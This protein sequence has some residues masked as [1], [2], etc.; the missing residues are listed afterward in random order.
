VTGIGSD[1]TTSDT[2]VPVA[3]GIIAALVGVK[4]ALHLFTN[5]FSP[6]EFH[7]D[8]FLYFAMGEHL[9]LWHMDFPPFIAMLSEATRGLLGDSL[10]A[11]RLPPALLGT[12]LLVFAALTARELGGGRFAQ[13]LAGFGVLSSVIFLRA[14]NLFQP[15]VVE[16]LCWTVGLFCLLKLCKS[17]HHRWWIAFGVACGIGLLTKF[18][19]LIFGF[20]TFIAILATPA[21]RW[22]S[23]PWPWLGA[24]IAFLIGSPSI[25]GQATLGFP[26]LDQMGDLRGGQLAQVSALS[27]L[28]EQ[29]TLLSG[30]LVAVIGAGALT[31]SRE[32]SRYRLVG[33]TC[34]A[35]FLTLMLL[36]GKSYYIAPIYPVLLGAGAVTLER[37]Q[38]PRWGSMLRWS[39]VAVMGIYFIVLLPIGLPI[40][41]PTMMERFLVTI[42][43]QNAATTN[44]GNQE[45]IPQD[46][47]DMLNW[48]EQVAEVARVYHALPEADRDRAVILASNY[49]EAGAIDFYGPRYDIPKAVSVV[50]T[51]WFFGPGDLPGDVT[52]M[53]GFDLDEIEE[54]CGVIEQAG[55][56]SHPF[57]VSEERN[58][59]VRICRE[60]RQTLQEL[61]P[62]QEG[63]N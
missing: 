25:V 50:G 26:V 58:L 56:V 4:L 48:R 59:S 39:I 10:F 22:L 45:R 41:P 46:F 7:R 55:T 54:H 35:A 24:G 6:Y 62:S 36:H 42:G 31:F 38:V 30:F 17:N 57:A 47:A 3:I 27:F 20:A 15:V 44:V 32:W 16:Q 43:A 49:G 40:L 63:N 61:W 9:R 60:P 13:G 2:P 12:A 34:V 19:M 5:A 1:G 53:H 23:T 33:L 51:Y 52:I 18:S 21:R 8:E 37:F 14:G 28:F 11:M 29:P